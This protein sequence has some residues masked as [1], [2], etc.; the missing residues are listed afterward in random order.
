MSNQS[1]SAPTGAELIAATLKHQGVKVIFGIVGIPVIEV[2]EAC[3]AAGIRFLAFR[4]EQSAAYAASAYGYLSGQPGVCLTVGG[5]GV[6]HALAGVANA[7]VNC[8]PMV[9]LA[10]SSDTDQVDMGAF[11]EWDQVEA[12]KPYC[13]YAARPASID[14]IPATVEK[15]MR[16]ALY[17]RPGA[18]YVDL[19]ADFIQYK[20]R[21]SQWLQKAASSINTLPSAA[22]KS[23]AD[24]KSVEQAVQLL[25]Q[26]KSPLIVVGKGAAYARA[27][28]EIRQLVDA[29]QIP[30]LPSPMGKGVVSDTHPLCVSAARSKALKE[31]DVVLLLGARLNW[32]FHYGQSPRWSQSV[33]FIHVDVLPEEIGNNGANTLPL[34]GDIQ[35]VVA[36]L[37]T[38]SLPRVPASNAYVSGLVEK[39]KQNVAK[40]LASRKKG[41]DSDV[42]NYQSA[43]TVV[44]E[45]L[46]PNDVIFVSEG[47]NTMDIARSFFDVHEPRHRLDAGTFATMGVGM[48]YAIAAQEY[49]PSKRVVSIV[50]D[51]AFGFSAMEL[52]T[53]VRSKLPLIILVINNNGIYHGLDEQEFEQS[54]RDGT[55]PSTALLP[56]TRYDQLSIAFGGKGW[57]AKDRVQLAKALKEALAV[58]D[59]TCVINVM[60]A[61]GG[62][63]KLE[64]GWMKKSEEKAKI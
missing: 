14:K 57:L 48:G 46:P 11:Q 64:F 10:G 18:A 22:P 62:R 32:I 29:T 2:A 13:K 58:K 1:E 61:P 54:R 39:V 41:S 4:N 45:L 49:Y 37:L 31:A 43:Y 42:M 47:A 60:I 25:R 44:K 38:Q 40:S 52:E 27:E 12:C 50:G 26:A 33:K 5:P 3:I 17:G 59:E 16:S 6:I 15:A 19:P 23:L 55:L 36:Q 8:W 28:K 9:L 20:I 51:S 35:A 56:D 7:K 53:A 63:T 34:V 21:D 24:P 30:F